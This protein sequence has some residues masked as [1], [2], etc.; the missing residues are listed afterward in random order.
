[1]VAVVLRTINQFSG[2]PGGP[3]V[4]GVGTASPLAVTTAMLRNFTRKTTCSLLWRHH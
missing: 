2:F 4:P 3:A 1:M